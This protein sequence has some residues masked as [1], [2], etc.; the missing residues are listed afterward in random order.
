MRLAGLCWVNTFATFEIKLVKISA[1]EQKRSP[2]C[3]LS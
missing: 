3:D 2:R 1:D